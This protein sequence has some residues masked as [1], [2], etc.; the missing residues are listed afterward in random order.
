MPFD[1]KTKE[2]VLVYC[3]RCCC[4]CHKFCGIK[5]EIHHIK[6]QA[7][8]GSDEFDNCIALCLE[9]HAEVGSY[10]PKHPKGNKFTENELKRHR[11]DWINK[12]KNTGGLLEFDKQSREVD[13]KLFLEIVNIFLPVNKMKHI[14]NVLDFNNAIPNRYISFLYDYFDHKI[15]S[16]PNYVFLDYILESSRKDFE[17]HLDS[18]TNKMAM[19]MFEFKDDKFSKVYPDHDHFDFVDDSITRQDTVYEL[20]KD[21]SL[22]WDLYNNFIILGRKRLMVSFEE[23]IG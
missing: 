16:L 21:A 13:R 17:L 7:Q 23:I 11:D 3:G 18:L 10:N 6:P 20:N 4:L 14:L 5:M 12:V 1:T 8:G 15:N 19:S 22:T 2:D 9:C